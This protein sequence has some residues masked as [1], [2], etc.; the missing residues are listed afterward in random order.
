MID[1]TITGMKLDYTHSIHV[2][3]NIMMFFFFKNNHRN[4]NELT[5]IC[6]ACSPVQVQN[7]LIC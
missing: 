7:E 6:K 3:S 1:I 5:F 2:K 4:R